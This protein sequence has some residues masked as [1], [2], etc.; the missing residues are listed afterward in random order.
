MYP[1][2][3]TPSSTNRDNLSSLQASSAVSGRLDSVT[4][5]VA[6]YP[7]APTVDDDET[8]IETE[9]DA[10]ATVDDDED[11]EDDEG[12][13]DDMCVVCDT[14]CTCKPK[15]S[16]SAD[17]L[18][19]P[20]PKSARSN[21]NPK[22]P[23][24]ALPSSSASPP[25]VPSRPNGS[26]IAS[27]SRIKSRHVSR[28]QQALSSPALTRN[29]P[30]KKRSALPVKSPPPLRPMAPST[31]MSPP[32]APRKR[33]GRP[34]ALSPQPLPSPPRLPAAR[35][36]DETESD[37]E[38]VIVHVP[39]PAHQF[40]SSR[41]GRA[42]SL[43]LSDGT[44]SSGDSTL[45]DD[46]AEFSSEVLGVLSAHPTG[47]H[48]PMDEEDA[49]RANVS[50]FAG[51]AAAALALL[52]S[53]DSSSGDDGRNSDSD[54]TVSSGDDSTLDGTDEETLDLSQQSVRQ[55]SSAGV[56]FSVQGIS[57]AEAT[58]DELERSLKRTA[59]FNGRTDV[60]IT[61]Y[62]PDGSLPSSTANQ[63]ED[64]DQSFSHAQYPSFVQGVVAGSSPS[65][66][67][68]GY[69][70]S[71]SQHAVVSRTRKI[72]LK[73]FGLG[74]LAPPAKRPREDH[75]PTTF[76]A[77]SPPPRKALLT[78]SHVRTD[79]PPAKRQRRPTGNLAPIVVNPLTV[80]ANDMATSP[81]TFKRPDGAPHTPTTP[82]MLGLDQIVD[83]DLFASSDD[84][85]LMAVPSAGSK[86]LHSSRRG[87]L[88][89]SRRISGTATTAARP[90]P[91]SQLPSQGTSHHATG[92]STAL[93]MSID[94]DQWITNPSQ[95][96]DYFAFTGDTD[97]AGL[98]Q[99]VDPD[100]MAMDVLFS[101]SRK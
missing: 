47:P 12:L 39:R 14:I 32:A 53:T 44:V 94:L 29:A 57:D 38:E 68:D 7:R 55:H 49:V 42:P 19:L 78:S 80:I 65:L 84:D 89:R 92:S 8:D 61:E 87:S 22:P 70:Q 2:I 18:P 43:G 58:E 20:P 37:E 27:S 16:A 3:P 54:M 11:D 5:S 98:S 67:K 50:T 88:G 95:N 79:E 85:D 24:P 96:Q 75:L 30:S 59:N 99:D 10:D 93:D 21:G 31:I 100:F 72:S 56:S 17:L 71:A 33:I 26:A 81:F 1:P 73:D 9:D 23:L 46:D 52:S 40:S 90:K 74:F 15:P 36:P 82:A 28:V 60:S 45:S 4:K 76:E 86:S 66:Y 35:P 77:E 34:P 83:A 64:R 63:R 48:E 91:S 97:S 41:F 101:E 69:N 51:L 6:I 25:L 62:Q 13:D